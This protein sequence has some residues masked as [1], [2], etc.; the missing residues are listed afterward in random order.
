LF[1]IPEMSDCP[2]CTT[3]FNLAAM[4]R[5]VEHDRP[6]PAAARKDATGFFVAN[7]FAQMAT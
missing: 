4:P 1:S 7:A 5:Q 3:R 6:V 2:G